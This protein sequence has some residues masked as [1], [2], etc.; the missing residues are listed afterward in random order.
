[1]YRCTQQSVQ[2]VRIV[3]TFKKRRKLH[4]LSISTKSNK[5]FQVGSIVTFVTFPEAKGV[6]LVSGVPLSNI[7]LGVNVSYLLL[8]TKYVLGGI[9][10]RLRETKTTT[11]MCVLTSGVVRSPVVHHAH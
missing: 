5:L 6:R 10:F 9:L 11:L 3:Y 8:C 7:K 1:M 2:E 4:K